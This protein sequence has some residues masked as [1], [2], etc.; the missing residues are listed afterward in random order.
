MASP[1][2]VTIER[3]MKDKNK[4]KFAKIKIRGIC[5]SSRWGLWLKIR[6]QIG[7]YL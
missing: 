4:T 2:L 5:A 3:E 1:N 6:V 7:N